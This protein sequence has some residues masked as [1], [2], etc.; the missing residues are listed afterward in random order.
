M[1]WSHLQKRSAQRSKFMQW[2]IVCDP[3]R[4][5]HIFNQ[6]YQIFSFSSE[7]INKNLIKRMRHKYWTWPFVSDILK[8]SQPFKNQVSPL[9][10]L[11]YPWFQTETCRFCRFA[12]LRSGVLVEFIDGR[13]SG[14]SDQ[15]GF[16]IHTHSVDSV[17]TGMLWF[18]FPVLYVSLIY[19]LLLL[20]WSWPFLHC[21]EKVQSNNWTEIVGTPPRLRPQMRP[22]CRC[23]WM[24]FTELWLKSCSA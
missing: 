24:S 23:G 3:F 5:L 19:S 11:H 21:G 16:C 4:F 10:E 14:I 8:D 17:P 22:F 15:T 9:H 6:H 2:H 12:P 20:P 18:Q 1:V 7:D 13:G